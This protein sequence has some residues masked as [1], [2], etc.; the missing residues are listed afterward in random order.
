MNTAIRF[1]HVAKKFI[2]HHERSRSFQEL[3][4][5]T[6]LRRNS[7]NDE[8]FWS[9]ND[10]SFEISPGESVALIGPNGAGK[11]TVLKLMSRILHPTRGK[12]EI[13]GR[14]SALL[15]LGSGFH[16]DMTGRENIFLNGSILGLSETQIRQ[17]L[18]AIIDFAEIER[19]VDL[20]VK[21]YSSG[22]YVRLGFAVAVH[23]E[24]DILLVDEVLAVGDANFQRKC[25]SKIDDLRRRGVTVCPSFTR[26]RDGSTNVPTRDLD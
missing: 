21:H 16:P 12:I 15:E 8:E 13:N 3:F 22:M 14:V 9:V 20:P 17:R 4:L 23:T 19:F 2:M 26:S 1:D 11:S 5:N 25:L 24:P 18:D 7:N 6:L 10:V